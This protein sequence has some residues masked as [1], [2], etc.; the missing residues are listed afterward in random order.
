MKNAKGTLL[1]TIKA[2]D[3]KTIV[4]RPG[5][6]LPNYFQEEVWANLM[7]LSQEEKEKWFKMH[8]DNEDLLLKIFGLHDEEVHQ[9]MGPCYSLATAAR[10]CPRG[11]PGDTFFDEYLAWAAKQK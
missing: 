9:A 7:A 3:G 5:N 6:H 4:Y 8:K 10:I 11:I 1:P 2:H